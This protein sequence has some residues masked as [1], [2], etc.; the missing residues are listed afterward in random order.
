MANYSTYIIRIVNDEPFMVSYLEDLCTNIASQ[1][2]EL[3]RPLIYSIN[4]GKR[5]IDIRYTCRRSLFN[6]D[7][8]DINDT[9]IV[10]EISCDEGGAMDWMTLNGINIKGTLNELIR[11]SK[12][13]E[14]AYE[15]DQL[16][17]YC[18]SECSSVLLSKYKILKE[19]ISNIEI[20]CINVKD[21]GFYACCS[22]DEVKGDYSL[23]ESIKRVTLQEFLRPYKSQ[24][25]GEITSE[26]PILEKIYKDFVTIPKSISEIIKIELLYKNRIV[27]RVERKEMFSYFTSNFWD[28]IVMDEK[29]KK[30]LLKYS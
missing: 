13:I 14:A 24:W 26:D 9:V 27:H 11:K 2:V 25:V 30:E 6:F 29:I 3:E 18:Q 17:F 7:E 22:Y 4:E 16:K 12:L 19:K 28:N 23:T 10:S 8:I 21:K 1:T 15:Y 20:D 5:S